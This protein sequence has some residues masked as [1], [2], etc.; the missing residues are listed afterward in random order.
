MFQIAITRN[1]SRRSRQRRIALN[2]RDLIRP[3]RIP[4]QIAHGWTS[5]FLQWCTTCITESR[6]GARDNA[7]TAA[8]VV[9]WMADVNLISHGVARKPYTS[10]P[11]NEILH[12]GEGGYSSVPRVHSF[13]SSSQARVQNYEMAS[14]VM[15]IINKNDLQN[16][17]E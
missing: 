14:E 12:S 1:V 2:K 16:S 10:L 8:L 17:A 5:N 3:Q 15:Q 7:I 6:T 9:L 13:S 11:S 4:P